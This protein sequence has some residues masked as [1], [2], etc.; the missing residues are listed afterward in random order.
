MA[1]KTIIGQ[2][3]RGENYFPRPNITERIWDKLEFGSNLLIVAPR[4]VGKTSILWNLLDNPKPNFHVVYYTSESVNNQNEFFKKL[5]KT[6][7]ES[8][9]GVKKHSQKFGNF[10]KELASR[11]EQI[12]L[13]GVSLGESKLNFFDEFSDFIKR[14]DF[15]KDRLIILVDEFAQTVENILLD[16]GE[17]EAREFLETNRVLRTSPELYKKIQF[18]YSGSIGLENI[19]GKIN[20]TG[21]INDLVSV[22]VKPLSRKEAGELV[23]KIINGSDISITDTRLDYLF[24][25]IHWLIPF[26]I[27]LIIDEGNNILKEQTEKTITNQIIDKAIRN[28]IKHRNY[29]ENWHERIR[30]AYQGS[31]FNFTKDLLNICCSKQNITSNE[32]LDLAVKYDIRQSFNTVLNALKHDGYLNNNDD[33]KVFVFNDPILRTWWYENV[34]Y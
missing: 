18:I 21:R 32:I 23:S 4:R 17:A 2:V 19:V 24:D 12:G 31:E 7:V 30:R 34:A 28:A 9:H 3:A 1:I 14:H 10:I 16:F 8:L 15:G 6:T 27:Q 29:F 20:Q 22:P 11:F 33:A 26:Y 13:E 25:K 5:M